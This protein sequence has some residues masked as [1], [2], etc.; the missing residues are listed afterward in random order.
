MRYL[1]FELSLV[2]VMGSVSHVWCGGDIC[3]GVRLIRDL[4]M[5]KER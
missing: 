4:E 3:M 2:G 5:V 1:S